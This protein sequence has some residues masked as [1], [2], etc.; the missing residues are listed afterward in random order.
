MSSEQDKK[1]DGEVEEGEGKKKLKD[2]ARAEVDLANATDAQ[3]A[4]QAATKTKVDKNSSEERDCGW[5][6]SKRGYGAR[7]EEAS[8]EK[9][10]AR[11]VSCIE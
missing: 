4:K 5:L 7:K 1:K 11:R 10:Q 8:A 9:S 2:K 6:P 3:Q